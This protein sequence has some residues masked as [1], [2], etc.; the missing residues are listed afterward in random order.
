MMDVALVVTWT[1]SNPNAYK[2]LISANNRVRDR[3]R[4]KE[5]DVENLVHSISK[6]CMLSLLLRDLFR[7][8]L[9]FE[10]SNNR[11]LCEGR[12]VVQFVRRLAS[13]TLSVFSAQFQSIGHKRFH[14]NYTRC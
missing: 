2:N 12:T 7:V 5:R 6:L 10:C 4:E 14:Q 11:F 8:M 3:E 13:C 1:L 9:M